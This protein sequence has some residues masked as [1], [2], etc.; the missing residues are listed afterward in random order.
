MLGNRRVMARVAAI[1]ALVFGAVACAGDEPRSAAQPGVTAARSAAAQSALPVSALPS[2]TASPSASPAAPPSP[3]SPPSSP[4]ATTK[5]LED[6]FK[7]RPPADGHG[8]AG[9]VIRTPGT[10]V[11]LTFDDGPDPINTPALLQILRENNVKA[12]FCMVGFRVRDRPD[13]V[14]QIYADGHTLCNHSWQHLTDLAKRDPSY[15]DWDLRHTNDMIHAA[16]GADAPIKYFRAPGGNFTPSLVA[17]A[18]ELGMSSIYW[19]VDPRDWDHQP[20]RNHSAHI[21]RV[22][23]QIKAQIRQGS[24]VLSHDNGQPDTIVAYRT[25]VPWLKQH[26]TLE[27]LPTA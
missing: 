23:S 22:I 12:T 7:I 15:I 13:L 17:K 10:E 19:D 5:T 3:S 24:I 18:Q 26:F 8:P 27:C 11:A 20:D 2:P 14:R 21:A 25:L 9:S 4:P 6:G 1:V 16:V